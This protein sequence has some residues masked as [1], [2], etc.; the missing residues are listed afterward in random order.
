M[1]GIIENI[2]Y[3]GDPTA[4]ANDPSALIAPG[5]IVTLTDG[6][7]FKYV[8]FDD[9]VGNVAAVAKT[10]C[11]NKTADGTTV[12]SDQS[13]GIGASINHV[14]GF[15]MNVPTDLRFTWIQIRGVLLAAPAPASTAQGDALIGSTTDVTLGRVAANTAP[16]NKVAAW[17][18][19]AVAANVS[20]VYVVVGG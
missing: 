14:A 3:P 20:D 6:R 1:Q 16:T 9:G 18:L 7:Q 10:A 2:G 4:G 17:A 19:T 12:T 11:Y 5:T 8:K 15:F 13:D